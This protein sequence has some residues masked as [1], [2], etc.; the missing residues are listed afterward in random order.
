MRYVDTFDELLLDFEKAVT[1]G[2]EAIDGALDAIYDEAVEANEA[3]KLRD[4]VI[5]QLG[6]ELNS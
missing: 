5:L 1:E 6:N 2:P 3:F 4:D